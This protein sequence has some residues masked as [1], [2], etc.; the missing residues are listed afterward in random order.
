MTNAQGYYNNAREE[1][2]DDKSVDP[3]RDFGY[4]TNGKCLETVTAKTIASI[5]EDHLIRTSITFHGGAS[6]IS[7]PWGAPNHMKKR[8]STEA[9]DKS[10]AHAVGKAVLDFS[11]A[12]LTI[13]PMTDEVYEVIGGLED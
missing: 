5:F 8:K 3:N 7:Y 9:P 12:D 1:R 4:M 10:A 13:G 2:M 11:K 6:S